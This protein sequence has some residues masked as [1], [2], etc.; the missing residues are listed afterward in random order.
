MSNIVDRKGRLELSSTNK[1]WCS[2]LWQLWLYDI[3]YVVDYE[4]VLVE[5]EQKKL[6]KHKTLH[7]AF[8]LY[9]KPKEVKQKGC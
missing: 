8:K 6:M 3:N 4:A 9:S 5:M 2:E 1:P 7:G